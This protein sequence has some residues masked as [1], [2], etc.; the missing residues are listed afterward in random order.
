MHLDGVQRVE[1]LD[2]IELEDQLPQYLLPQKGG[3]PL[4]VEKDNPEEAVRL[5]PRN[6]RHEQLEIVNVEL[7]V[8]Q[9]LLAGRVLPPRDL[10]HVLLTAH[11]AAGFVLGTVLLKHQLELALPPLPQQLLQ[12]HSLPA[13]NAAQPANLRLKIERPS[14]QAAQSR[15]LGAGG[16][17]ELA[18]S[19]AVHEGHCP[20]HDTNYYDEAAT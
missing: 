15:R 20:F 16:E 4:A 13:V 6:L 1:E 11:L 2:S 19:L 9:L 5:L 14:H 7:A 8:Q 12:S 17:Y 18:A 3:L 10:A